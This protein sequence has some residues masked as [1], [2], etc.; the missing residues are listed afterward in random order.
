ML[1]LFFSLYESTTH[2]KRTKKLTRKH[3]LKTKAD[4]T[5]VRYCDPKINLYIY[6]QRT[7]DGKECDTMKV[8]ELNSCPIDSKKEIVKTKSQTEAMTPAFVDYLAYPVHTLYKILKASNCKNKLRT[9]E[10][11]YNREGFELS[12]TNGGVIL[13][14]GANLDPQPNPDHPKEQFYD[15]PHNYILYYNQ[16]QFSYLF[17]LNQL[18]KAPGMQEKRA[19]I[20]LNSKADLTL[21]KMVIYKR[22]FLFGKSHELLNLC[23][24]NG[25]GQYYFFVVHRG[26]AH[27]FTIKTMVHFMYYGFSTSCDKWAYSIDDNVQYKDEF[28]MTKI[29]NDDFRSF[30]GF[31]ELVKQYAVE[32]DW[33]RI[34]KTNCQHFATGFFN[35][36]SGEKIKTTNLGQT[37]TME[38]LK[39]KVFDARTYD[40]DLVVL[41][42][43][44]S[45]QEEKEREEKDD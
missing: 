27:G 4:K 35:T 43:K 42:E 23:Y 2:L 33:Y 9:I 31:F 24:S 30:K 41:P 36:L 39:N 5:F 10:R 22:P 34:F 11:I 16:P 25:Y 28:D 15:E 26:K 38:G 18:S 29:P 7:K 3:H 32:Y 14:I 40:E 19:E 37:P 21:E 13:E 20:V 8:I 12:L 6:V 44:Y 1:F 45:K 17:L